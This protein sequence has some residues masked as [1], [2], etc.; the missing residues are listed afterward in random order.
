MASIGSSGRCVALALAVAICT[1]MG[2]SAASDGAS[3]PPAIAAASSLNPA[4]TE[5]A[6]AFARQYGSQVRLSYGAS[7]NIARQIMQGAPFELF[8]SADEE[9]VLTVVQGGFTRGEEVLYAQGHLALFV[10]RRS[11]L[12]AD[13]GLEDLAEAVADGRL[14]RLA[15]A[16]PEHAPYGRA[17]RELLQHRAL[18]DRVRD[19]LVMGESVSQATQFAASGSV[20]AGIVS[21]SSAL[22]PARAGRGTALLLPPDG[23]R[24]LRHRMV[25]LRNAGTV[26]HHFFDFMTSRAAQVILARHGFAL[27]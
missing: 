20:D 18:W 1:G 4:L 19:K 23:Y 26:A 9:H 6:E 21:Y 7:G 25:L 12:L 2:G 11:A 14:R 5:V 13:A 10:P 24:P 22:S 8:M 16:N 27:P 17:A 3:T 15:I